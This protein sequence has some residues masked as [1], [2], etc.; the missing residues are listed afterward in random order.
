MAI[1]RM[2]IAVENGLNKTGT[3]IINGEGILDCNLEWLEQYPCDLTGVP[4]DVHAVQ[5]YGDH[6]EIELVTNG[7]NIQITELGS[8]GIAT[9]YFEQRKLEVQEEILAKELEEENSD[10]Y[11]DELLADLLS[12]EDSTPTEEDSTPTEEVAPEAPTE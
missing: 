12:E 6:G 3:I 11:F 8:I 7:P 5:W 9:S 2:T 10:T 1:D 4:V